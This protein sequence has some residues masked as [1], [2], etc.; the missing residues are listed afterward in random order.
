MKKYI[1]IIGII[2][3]ILATSIPAAKALNLYYIQLYG[4]ANVAS[5]TSSFIIGGNSTTT[6]VIGSD[7]FNQVSWLV[8]L[9][10]SSTPPTLCWKNQYSNN[11]TDWYTED[12]QYASSTIHISGNKS[13]CWTYS[14]TTSGTTIISNGSDGVTQYVG[15]KIV[16]PNL[17]TQHTRT[18][19]SID[20]G[21]SARLDI[22][23]SLKNEV[24]LNK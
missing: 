23:G 22:R 16:V 17:D 21:V 8:A 13:E 4:S 18:V 11:G 9:A 15:R 5:T 12:S 20:P 24:K 2:V 10:S 14:T 6:K 3:G 19:F 1:L 7:G